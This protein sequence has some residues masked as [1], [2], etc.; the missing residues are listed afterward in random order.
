MNQAVIHLDEGILV[1]F[2]ANNFLINGSNVLTIEQQP[3]KLN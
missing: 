1:Y 3:G 2:N